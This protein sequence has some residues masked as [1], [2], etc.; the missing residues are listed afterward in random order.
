[1]TTPILHH[2]EISPFS[3]KIRLILG[4]KGIE[5]RSVIVPSTL[6]KPEY[7]ALTG[8]YRR[9]PVLQI[10]ADVYCDTHLIADEI[11]RRWP[12]PSLY[13][14]SRGL[15]LAVA[16]W[17]ESRLFWPAAR[18]ATGLNADALPPEFHADRAAMRGRPPPSVQ[19]IRQ[20]AERALVQL[21]PQIDWIGDAL[22]D[23]RAFLLGQRI[24]LADFA[25]YHCLWFLARFPRDLL[26]ELIPDG[27]VRRWMARIASIGHGVSEDMT[28]ADALAEA[29]AWNPVSAG[30]LSTMDG[31]YPDDPVEVSPEE[32]T[33]A[34][35]SGRVAGLTHDTITIARES[36]ETGPV[37]IHF[38][39]LGY[40][41][42][43]L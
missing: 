28:A 20:A 41:E 1:M 9:V 36:P 22:G 14:S 40:I 19:Q 2:Y 23:G 7:T 33:S 37:H 30:N 35:V 3:E 32:R 42:E 5:W 25:V 12:K 15:H 18:Y 8:G 43:K 6:P 4:L 10:G 16:S 38:P 39:R 11:E 17:A 31:L 26:S 13:P 27:P 24:G 21:R 29:R 34:P